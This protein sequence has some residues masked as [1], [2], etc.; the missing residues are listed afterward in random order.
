MSIDDS[1]KNR[2]L[3]GVEQRREELI[4][5]LTGLVKIPSVVGKEG[6]AQKLVSQLYKSA[7]LKVVR[8]QADHETIKAHEAFIE[9]SLPYRNRPNIIGIKPGNK[10]SKSL[11]LN[12]HIDVVSTRAGQSMDP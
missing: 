3:E 5:V 7:G 10:K 2:V 12:G 11:I 4:D 6:N 9:S 1:I 8:F